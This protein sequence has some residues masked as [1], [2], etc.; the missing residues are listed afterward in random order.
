MYGYLEL[1]ATPRL[2]RVDEE[3]IRVPDRAV[4]DFE[5]LWSF[6]HRYLLERDGFRGPDLAAAAE[7][8]EAEAEAA[9]RGMR[10]RGRDVSS[11]RSPSPER[12]QQVWGRLAD[13]SM[14]LAS[15][16]GLPA[17]PQELPPRAPP[18]PFFDTLSAAAETELPGNASTGAEAGASQLSGMPYRGVTLPP[19][20]AASAGVHISRHGSIDIHQPTPY[21]A[22]F[23]WNGEEVVEEESDDEFEFAFAD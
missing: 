20:S 14:P 7:A 13:A 8:A 6:Y 17:A 1:H 2:N 18:R 5:E 12:V 11:R 19:P 22:E 16:S 21:E 15:L 23:A 10:E 3:A 9:E 4:M